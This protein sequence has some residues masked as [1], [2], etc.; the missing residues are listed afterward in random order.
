MGAAQGEE[1][2]GA[3]AQ[4]NPFF[5]AKPVDAKYAADVRVSLKA[6]MAYWTDVHNADI[7]R[8][9]AFLFK[10]ADCYSFGK[11]VGAIAR[12][13]LIADELGELEVARVGR[14]FLRCRLNQWLDN[15]QAASEFFPFVGPDFPVAGALQGGVQVYDTTWGGLPTG[16]GIKNPGPVWIR[17]GTQ[18]DFGSGGYN[19][20]LFH[21]GYYL[22]AVSVVVK[23]A[24]VAGGPAPGQAGLHFG[25]ETCRDMSLSDA[26][27]FTP[28]SKRVFTWARDISN[29]NQAK[30]PYFA[31]FRYHSDWYEGHSW[32]RGLFPSGLTSANIESTSEAM[33]AW[34]SMF[35]LGYAIQK[36]NIAT[37]AYEADALM[38]TAS[39]VM[40]TETASVNYYWHL[41]P[42]NAPAGRDDIMPSLFQ[43][44]GVTG[45]LWGMAVNYQ[46]FFSY[47][48]CQWVENAKHRGPHDSCPYD[49]T[50]DQIHWFNRVFVLQIQLLPYTAVTESLA[51]PQW[52]KSVMNT[53]R[54]NYTSHNGRGTSYG[55]SPEVIWDDLPSAYTRCNGTSQNLGKRCAQGWLAYA[56][57]ALATLGSPY[58]EMAWS[59]A[60]EMDGV[61]DGSTVTNMLWWIATR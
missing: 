33:Q 50:L 2:A 5:T 34:Y 39:V 13:V 23:G 47:G 12:L 26:D 42:T 24:T 1:A 48:G 58:K 22:Y 36:A 20:H 27:W 43:R 18:P 41:M 54:F 32:A 10:T 40:L 49:L 7:V 3:G 56:Y 14:D 44:L 19:D 31:Q 8:S 51:E 11:F 55:Y 17:N 25:E 38:T 16:N 45:N 53:T 29:P 30:D 6:D 9:P 57:Q 59:K 4:T 46:V 52:L 37:L 35:L 28:V 61:A 60:L 15:R 21:Y